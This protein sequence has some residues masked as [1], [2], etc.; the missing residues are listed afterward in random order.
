MAR[1]A[2]EAARALHPS[3]AR[4][5]ETRGWRSLTYIQENSIP[6]IMEGANTLI[7]APT[8]EGKTEA[9]LLPILSMMASEP[10]EP[11]TLLYITPMKALINDLYIRISWWAS[12]L[13]FRVARKHGDTTATERNRRLRR[14]PHILVTTP[15]SLEIDLDWSRKF[16]VYYRNLRWVIIDEVHE[17]LSNKRGAQF[18]VQLERLSRIAG[19]DIQR[20]GLS[21]TIGD[22]DKA[23]NLI[24]GSSRR[25]RVIVD[26][27]RAK[28][29]RLKVVYVPED[30]KDPWISIAKSVIREVEKPSLVFV[31]SRY[32]AEKIKDSLE[33]LEA[34]DVFVH[35]SSVS[36]ELREEAEDRLRRGELS[37]IVCTKTLEVGIDVGE[38]RKVIQVR[39]PGRVASLLQRVGRSGH[40]LGGE[41]KGAIVSLGP[42]DYAESLAEAILAQEGYVENVII[43]RIPLDVVAKEVLGMAMERGGV[44]E[45]E[46]YNIISASS[47]VAP[48]PEEFQA[49]LD[50]MERNGVIRRVMGVIR[51]GPVFY[52][53]WQFRGDRGARMWWSRDFSEFFS[54]IPERDSF[55]VKYGDKTIGYVDAVFVYRYLRVGDTI[56]LAGKSWMVKRIDENTSRI[57]VEPSDTTAEVPL[58]RGEGPRRSSTVA[59][60]FM[61]V[62]S[63]LRSPGDVETDH[64]GDERIYMLRDRYRK[65]GIEPPSMDTIIYERYGDEHI[66]TA[67]LGSGAS[68]AIAILLSYLASK[69]VGLNVYYRSTFFGFSIGA[70]GFDPLSTLL[71]LDL[72]ELE[73]LIYKAVER[74]P[75]LFQV[76]RDIQLDLGKIGSIDFDSDRIIVEEAARQVVEEY[77]D[78]EGAR[79][80]I[81]RLQKGEVKVLKPDIGGL[82]P[83]ALELTRFPPIKPWLQDLT[84]RIARMLEGTAL[85]LIELADLLELAEKTIDSR[86][87]EM[88]KPDYGEH[89]VV[90]FI[91]VDEDEWR[92]V[93]VKDL[94]EVAG[95]EEFSHNF[96]PLKKREP[97]R[98]IIKPSQGSKHR[99][100]IVTPE[101]I[102]DN[103]SNLERMLPDE[104]YMVKISSAYSEGSRDDVSVTHYYVP[105]KVM[106]HIILNAATYIQRKEWEMAV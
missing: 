48:T 1:I 87:R 21:A 67:P 62:L 59:R 10:V 4:L 29:P 35:H 41:S 61:E 26:G 74:S 64:E 85:T 13:G 89:R 40:S 47:A 34:R 15:E 73:D 81:E 82:T 52:K 86:L 30:S 33:R 66:V 96:T 78:V 68:E 69:G 2:S 90:G 83:L 24:S 88:R 84:L 105:S 9:A 75:Y 36:A 56:R 18:I 54:T 57:E 97:L 20:I 38:I 11:V 8:G 72:N 37:A 95:M 50:Y 71:S 104:I 51:P 45:S 63:G 28:K 102:E 79:V 103:W 16:R 94:E 42:I 53:I 100:L 7:V 65:L 32:V 58:W 19:R 76:M 92:W 25:P 5:V 39:A 46:A 44:H 106:K 55:I 17:L 3:V 91:D 101:T 70:R 77:L 60:V 43:D 31:N 98:L 99:E 23:L 27:R 49:M 93:L 22:L 6:V 12:R 14:A 80:F